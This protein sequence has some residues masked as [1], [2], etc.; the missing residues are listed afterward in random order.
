MLLY[1]HVRQEKDKITMSLKSNGGKKITD[2]KEICLE[3]NDYKTAV[4]FLKSIGCVEKAYQETKREL[5]HF[6]NAEITIDEWPHLEPLVEIEA[7]S[8][9]IVR[10]TAKKMGFDYNQ[11]IFGS[12]DVIYSKKYHLPKSVFCENTPNLLFNQPNPFLKKYASKKT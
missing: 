8:E 2:Q 9:K 10:E 1:P 12:T 6:N 5:W 7:K 4:T 11:A 3:V